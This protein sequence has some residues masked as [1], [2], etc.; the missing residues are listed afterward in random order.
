MLESIFALK[1]KFISCKNYL[2]IQNQFYLNVLNLILILDVCLNYQLF[3]FGNSS[4][5]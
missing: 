1:F 2:K 4:I 3:Y 5:K